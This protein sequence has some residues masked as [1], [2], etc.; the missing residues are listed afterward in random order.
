MIKN[1]SVLIL[2]VVISIGCQI[3]DFC[4][5]GTTSNL[6]IGFYDVDF[7]DKIKP[8][9]SLTVWVTDKDTLYRYANVDSILIP[10]D[11]NNDFTEYNFMARK[12]DKDTLIFNYTRE[13]VFVSRSCGYKY[14]FENLDVDEVS[15]SW[16]KSVIVENQSVTNEVERHV[17]ILH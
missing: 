13:E 14:N 8:T 10:L 16:I 5:E 3:D 12:N 15:I 2:L 11:P 7:P 4:T 17:K 9:D 1:L 6:H